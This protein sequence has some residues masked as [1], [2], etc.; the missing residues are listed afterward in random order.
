MV[1]LAIQKEDENEIRN[2]G[3]D[4]LN[5]NS[6]ET[7]KINELLASARGRIRFAF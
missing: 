3:E 7:V 5:V 1:R 6:V 2:V 4:G